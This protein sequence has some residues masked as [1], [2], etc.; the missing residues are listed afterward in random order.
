MNMKILKE[1]KLEEH[2]QSVNIADAN[3]DSR[4]KRVSCLAIIIFKN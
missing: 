4:D 2:K 3:F 1:G